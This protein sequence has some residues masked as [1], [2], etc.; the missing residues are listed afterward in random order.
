MQPLFR[1]GFCYGMSVLALVVGVGLAVAQQPQPQAPASPAAKQLQDPQQEAVQEKAQQ[2]EEGKAGTVEPA[3]LVPTAKPSATDALFN[4]A[5]AVPGAPTD[6]QTVPSKYSARNA[7]LDK[8]PLAE[9]PGP[10]QAVK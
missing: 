6:S 7:A 2:K 1:H 5:L 3:T 4:G 8:V 10:A 9:W